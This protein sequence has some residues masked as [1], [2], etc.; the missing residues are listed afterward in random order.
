ML[1]EANHI[2]SKRRR[3]KNTRLREGGPLTAEEAYELLDEREIHAQLVNDMS[4]EQGEVITDTGAPVT[5]RRCGV[6]RT[7]GHNA[8][9]C[10][11]RVEIVGTPVPDS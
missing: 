3:E 10:P 9:S 1:Q 4:G 8:R 6:C 11:N 2:L 7:P 5:V